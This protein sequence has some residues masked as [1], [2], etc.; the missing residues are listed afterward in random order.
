MIM[1]MND[2]MVYDSSL[3]VTYVTKNSAKIECVIIVIY[4]VSLEVLLMK[5]AT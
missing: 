5:A 2:K 4:L 3:F 1:S